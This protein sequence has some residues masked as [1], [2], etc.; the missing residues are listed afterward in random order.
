[1]SDNFLMLKVETRIDSRVVWAVNGITVYTCSRKNGNEEE[2]YDYSRYFDFGKDVEFYIGNG[3]N[4][5]IL[6]QV[7]SHDE[8][9]HRIIIF[10]TNFDY[11]FTVNDPSMDV[12]E[13]D[14][15]VRPVTVSLRGDL[16]SIIKKHTVNEV[17]LPWKAQ[18]SDDVFKLGQICA[19]LSS[20]IKDYKS[21]FSTEPKETLKIKISA[22]ID[23]SIKLLGRIYNK[24]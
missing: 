11:V 13:S 14:T 12:K 9:I 2:R 3:G 19:M 1:M 24:H 7:E 5:I 16:D 6:E 15:T 4:R 10:P 21:S 22:N 17:V 20:I 23:E 18:T 8:V